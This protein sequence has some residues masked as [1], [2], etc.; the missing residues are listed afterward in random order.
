[1]TT[2]TL[3]STVSDLWIPRTQ[4]WNHTLLQNTFQQPI[5]Q[6]ITSKRM[7]PQHHHDILRWKPAKDG[8]CTTKSIYKHLSSENAITLPM[9]GSRSILPGA[10]YILNRAWKSKSL[11]P[12]IKALTWRLIRRALATAERATRYSTNHNNQ[13]D[14]CQ[15]I[16]DDAHLFFH[17][18]VH[19]FFPRAVW[20]TFSPAIITHHLPPE[21]D[22]VQAILQTLLNN[23]TPEPIFCKILLT[24]W[25]IW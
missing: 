23:Q 25:Y 4:E 19:L 16:E 15:A 11:P 14:S 9:Q 2:N 21:N 13:C 20:Y 1:M 8:Q 22:G 5:L 6:H 12:L 18:M 7:V 10:Q 3:P 17:C 24:L